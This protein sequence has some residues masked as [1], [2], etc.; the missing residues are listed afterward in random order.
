MKMGHSVNAKLVVSISGRSTEVISPAIREVQAKVA[1]AS[2]A[3][4]GHAVAEATAAQIG[5]A[6]TNPQR[7]AR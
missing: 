3:E 1:L 4:L 6:T 5:W 2:T 7:R